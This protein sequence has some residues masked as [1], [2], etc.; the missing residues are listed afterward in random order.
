MIRRSQRVDGLHRTQT[1]ASAVKAQLRA[2]RKLPR[3]R[4]GQTVRAADPPLHLNGT[5]MRC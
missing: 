1:H 3:L 2:S 5:N 4:R